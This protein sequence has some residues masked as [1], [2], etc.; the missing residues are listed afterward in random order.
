[1]TNKLIISNIFLML[2]GT[3]AA[4]GAQIVALTISAR[5]MSVSEFGEIG[6]IRT[7]LATA[8]LAT[9]ASFATT[10][11]RYIAAGENDQESDKIGDVLS[12]I[13]YGILIC[14]ALVVSAITVWRHELSIYLFGSDIYGK[15]IS[16][17][18]VVIAINSMATFL[19]G[20]L[21]GSSKFLNIAKAN[22]ITGMVGV[23]LIVWLAIEYKLLGAVIAFGAINFVTL[24]AAWTYT[25][26]EVMLA[27]IWR[28]N[29]LE[30]LIDMRKIFF[31]F[32]GPSFLASALV[33]PVLLI[34]QALVIRSNNGSENLGVFVAAMN[35]GLMSLI[36]TQV[37]GQVIYP[38]VIKNHSAKSELFE[39]KNLTSTWLVG[40]VINYP[41]L[42]FS[43]ELMSAYGEQYSTEQGSLALILIAFTSIL[44]CF[45]QGVSR[46]IAAVDMMWLSVFSNL[47]WAVTSLIICF[48][49]IESGVLAIPIA[50]LAGHIVSSIVMFPVFIKYGIISKGYVSSLY[51]IFIWIF[52]I[53]SCVLVVNYIHLESSV[54]RKFVSVLSVYLVINLSLLFWFRRF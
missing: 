32:S 34:T 2:G 42:V 33:T 46:C 48:Y 18:A 47:I 29:V 23:P 19:L 5:Y 36:V 25:N 16:L 24:V 8:G 43:H 1:M 17:C 37:V 3:L 4:R 30:N 14:L 7:F 53:L 6:I 45:K 51:F 15:E 10:A 41:V 52:I 38:H 13:F 39:F 35:V 12:A 44:Q 49:N 40:I 50:F 31:H 54:L 21:A 27:A 26:K 11:T 22:L 20:V 28:R 9:A